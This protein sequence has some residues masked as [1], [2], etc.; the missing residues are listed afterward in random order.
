[1]RSLVLLAAML[2]SLSLQAAEDRLLVWRLQHG[3]AEMVLLGSMHMARPGLYP[4][5][6]EIMQAFDAADKLVVE[7]DI[8]GPRE[9][10]I[11][12][13]MMARG[14]YPPGESLRDHVSAETWRALEQT[15]PAY[16]LPMIMVQQMKPGLVAT[17]LTVQSM[18]AMGLSP[19][20][21]VDAYFLQ[22]SAGNKQVL[23]LETVEQQLSLLL[24][25]PEADL[26]LRHTLSQ[27][28][29]MGELLEPMESS[30]LRGDADALAKVVLDDELEQHPE[31]API[32]KR[33]FDDRNHAMTDS[34]LGYLRQGG[35]YFVV[36]GA[37]HLVGDQGI[38]R[39]LQQR[40]YKLEQF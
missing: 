27:L 3:N 11:Q 36:V 17:L 21:G 22:R 18:V 9:L 6:R 24:D 25:I 15:L 26:F 29:R 8:S 16:G 4:L 10:E 1:M 19:E 32:L 2:F 34:L 5:R 7:I 40:G 39:L 30:W 33:L 20:R 37:G 13:Q 38:V 23:E 31:F 35:S 14:T 28:G 12:Q